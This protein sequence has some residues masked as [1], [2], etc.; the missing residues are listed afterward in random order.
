MGILTKKTEVVT[1]PLQDAIDASAS[2]LDVFYA[3][4]SGLDDANDQLAAI[5]SVEQAAIDQAQARV[6]AAKAQIVSNDGVKAKIDKI[7]S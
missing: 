3:A 5:V 1:D 4:A 6:N 2:A 7:L